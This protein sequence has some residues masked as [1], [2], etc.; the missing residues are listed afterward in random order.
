MSLHNPKD[1][2]LKGGN[3]RRYGCND[4]H[5]F[6][7]N[8]FEMGASKGAPACEGLARH[9]RID[10]KLQRI[11]CGRSYRRL[12]D[13]TGLDRTETLDHPESQEF[14]MPTCPYGPSLAGDRD[15]TDSQEWDQ[16]GIAWP[17]LNR[18][19]HSAAPWHYARG[20]RVGGK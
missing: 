1:N 9:R 13:Q 10:P 20:P 2:M 16:P 15:A 19:W 14:P 8:I 6:N 5:S 11:T 4:L 18:E 17:D 12:L 7:A 3:C